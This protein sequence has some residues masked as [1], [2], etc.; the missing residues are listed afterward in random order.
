MII[1]PGG[2][3]NKRK[4]GDHPDNS[5]IKNGQD[6]EK[7]PGDLRRLAVTQTP[8]ENQQQTLVWK[9]CKGVVLTKKRES[10]IEW[11]LPSRGTKEWE[12]K[13]TKRE[14]STLTFDQRIKKAVEQKSYRD[15]ICNQYTRSGSQRLIKGAGK[16]GNWRTNRDHTNYSTVEVGQNTEKSPG[17]LKRF[18]VTQ[19]PLTNPQLT[20]LIRPTLH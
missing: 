5:I 4:S 19:N 9:T 6:T 3:V 14:A 12:L 13:K 20:F 18:A 16:V 8:L 1:I 15:T 7:G 10:A 17:D 11:T 2:L